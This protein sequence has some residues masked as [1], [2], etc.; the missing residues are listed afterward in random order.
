[1]G[2]IE[3][4]E[5]VASSEF[6]LN[7]KILENE[8]ILRR[9]TLLRKIATV[10][11]AI[12]PPIVISLGVLGNVLIDFSRPGHGRAT[13]NTFTVIITIIAIAGAVASL[14]RLYN[15]IA[16]TNLELSVLREAL[17]TLDRKNRGVT[18]KLGTHQTYMEAVPGEVES[19]RTGARRYRRVHNVLQTVIIAGSIVS[20]SVT[21]AI[22]EV[23]WFKIAAPALSMVVGISAGMT[24]YFK[25]RERSMNLQMTA[26]SIE[27]EHTAV[28][29]LIRRYKGKSLDDAL[30][31][32]AEE[33]E[34]LKEEQRKRE[35]QL[36]QPPEGGQNSE[37][38]K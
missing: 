21:S 36:D 34:R 14:V 24:G 19:Y 10:A 6:E 18:K 15:P 8:A 9:L 4:P 20:A 2:E 1:V 5:E 32:F 22:S 11:L 13:L 28:G 7:A 16:E 31:E 26:D 12:V 23:S 38:G 37:P 17:Q 35:Q 30:V 27:Q 29:L 25:F 3:L 33:V